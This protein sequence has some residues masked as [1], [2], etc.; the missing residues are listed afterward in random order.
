MSAES[1]TKFR[2]ELARMV[3]SSIESYRSHYDED[4]RPRLRELLN[5]VA[6]VSVRKA[7]GDNTGLAEAA[8]ESSLASVALGEQVLLQRHGAEIALRAALKVA[9][10]LGAAL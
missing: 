6:V 2:D 9:G 5:D 3:D 7:A 4:T 8:L 10:V 1:W